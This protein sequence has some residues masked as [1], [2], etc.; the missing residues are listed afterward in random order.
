MM[1]ILSIFMSVNPLRAVTVMVCLLVASVME[2]VGLASLLPVLY[3]ATDQDA[4]ES[5]VSQFVGSFLEFFSLSP[6]LGPLLAL[7]ITALV[8][9]SLITFFALTFVG[10]T[11]ADVVTDLRRK[12]VSNLL[13]VR[14]RY[15]V[16]QPSGRIANVISHDATR[17]ANAYSLSAMTIAMIGQAIV[18]MTVALVV[19][20]KL[21]IIALVVG[22][23][24]MSALHLLVKASKKAGKAQ[25]TRTKKLVVFLTDT[26]AN[27]KLIRAMNRQE[28]FAGLLEKRISRLRKA[29]RQVVFTREAVANFQDIVMSIF[30]GV[31][32]YVLYKN[33][34]I[35]LPELLVSGIVIAK[36][37]SA[38]GKVQKSYQKAVVLQSAF[39]VTRELIEET[40]NDPEPPRGHVVPEFDTGLRFE[41]VSFAYESEPVLR[42]INLT[43]RKGELTVFLGPSGAGKS[44]IVDLIFSLYRPNSGM[45]SIDSVPINEIDVKAWRNQLGYV[46]QDVILLHDTVAAN[47]TL[48]DQ[49][50]TEEQIWEALE[51]AGVDDA[52]R[53][54][55]E[56]LE[57]MVGE[58]GMRFSG[59]QRQRLALARALVRK[60]RLLVLDE[61]T[62]ALDHDTAQRVAASIADLLPQTTILAVTH[63]PEF[64]D[65]A[66]QIYRIEGGTAKPSRME[67]QSS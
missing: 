59:G 61:V 19:S 4:S 42:D 21:A 36:S 8:L 56:G 9:K 40:A 26:L 37:V 60:P 34:A 57:T 14:W 38:L 2:G 63:R 12:I 27:L 55:P 54:L 16:N 39:V 48:G 67:L 3:I 66:D 64:V 24:T 33:F 23:L 41:N 28:P 20:F 65:I 44:T 6:E 46:P 30:L 31:G 13:N 18:M 29:L 25:T 45:L 32:F 17:A 11:A 43:I 50:I 62:S 53:E 22:G 49:S 52:V 15:L 10:Y 7:T 5:A 47:L 1:Q 35:P 58:R 51:L